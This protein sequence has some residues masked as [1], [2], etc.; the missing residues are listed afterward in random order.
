MLIADFLRD[1]LTASMPIRRLASIFRASRRPELAPGHP[2][3]PSAA[4]P[5]LSVARVWHIRSF[6]FHAS[7]EIIEISNEF[8]ASARRG[9]LASM[10]HASESGAF[11]FFRDSFGREASHLAASAG[12]SAALLWLL[13]KGCSPLSRDIMGWTPAHHAAYRGSPEALLAAMS[14][15]FDARRADSRGRSIAHLASLCGSSEC[16]SIAL[17]CGCDPRA[18]D[19]DGKTCLELAKPGSAALDLLLSLERSAQEANSLESSLLAPLAPARC[20]RSAPL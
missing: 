19:G 14:F 18:S 7:P 12:H 15:G 11:L 9:D 1:F 2:H 4:T 5:W 3:L 10:A 8:L 6:R 16:L 20:G 13:K 17:G